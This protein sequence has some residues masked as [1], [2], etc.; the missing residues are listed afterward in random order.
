MKWLPATWDPAAE[1]TAEQWVDWFLANERD[2]QLEIAEWAI[3]FSRESTRCL[4]Q[5]GGVA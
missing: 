1:P 2:A 5:H 4:V 3:R